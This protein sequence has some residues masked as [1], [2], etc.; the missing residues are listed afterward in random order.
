MLGHCANSQQPMIAK[1]A[2]AVLLMV[3]LLGIVACGDGHG[4]EGGTTA[5]PDVETTSTTGAESNEPILIK[6]H[7]A[8]PN[9]RGKMS[10]EVTCSP[11][12]LTGQAAGV[13]W[14]CPPS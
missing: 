10:G 14:V 4:N 8:P 11:A 12:V 9:A 6:T 7:L 1:T 2:F 13:R 5:S 3:S